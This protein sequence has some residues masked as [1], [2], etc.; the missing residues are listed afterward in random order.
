MPLNRQSTLTSVATASESR[1]DVSS[2]YF[3]DETGRLSAVD[4]STAYMGAGMPAASPTMLASPGSGPYSP[5]LRS[6]NAKQQHASDGFETISSPGEI[7]MQSFADGPPAPPVTHSWKRIDNWAEENYPE[8]YDQLCEAATNNDLN[9][10]EHQ[11]DCTLPPDIRDS[12]MVHDGQERGGTP[13]G[14]IFGCMLLDCEEMVQE[15]DQWLKVNQEYLLDTSIIKPAVPTR[16]FGGSNQASS[17][18]SATTSPSGSQSSTWRQDLLAKQD[19]VPVGAVQR[20]YA[21]PAWIP[22][23]RDWGGNNLAVDLAPG[24]SGTWGQIILFGRDYD[25]KYVVA[26]SWAHFIALVADD[27]NSGRWYVDE[28]TKELKLREFNTSRVEPSYFDILRWRMDQKNGRGA[29]AAAKRRSVG[30]R[31]HASPSSSPYVSPVDANVNGEARGRT[32]QRLN[33][34]S[35]LTSPRPGFGTSSPLAR[36]TE[37]GTA[38]ALGASKLATNG[39]KPVKLV[40]IDTPRPSED[41]KSQS[42]GGLSDGDASGKGKENT[43]VEASQV[44]GKD[45]EDIEGGMKDIEI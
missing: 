2:P 1:A 10:L 42:I 7:P 14:I 41:V 33:N 40:E 5:G 36:V 38:S 24:P 6:M 19:S 4:A 8:L 17:S 23:V 27:L 9:E 28:E 20:V 30:P 32:L 29:K 43:K 37:E 11:L 34:P 26:K 45:I 18:K 31:G 22:L 3:A 16:A 12:L 25:I 21:H 44:N 13:T 39:V 15:R 35:P